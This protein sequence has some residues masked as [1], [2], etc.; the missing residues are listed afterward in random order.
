MIKK[1][2]HYIYINAFW[3]GFV[4]KKDPNNID[5]FKKIFLQSK[6]LKNFEITT[7]IH[8]ANVLFESISMFGQSLTTIKNWKYKIHYSGEPFRNNSLDYDLVLDSEKSKDNNIVDLPLCVYYT[9]E[10]CRL[11]KLLNRQCITKIPIEFCC[12]IVSNGNC[13]IRNN[14]F[15]VLN[16]YKKVHSYGRFANNMG[17]DSNINHGWGTD[18]YINFIRK[19]KFIICFENTKKGTYITEKIVNPYLAQIVPIYWGT[20]HVKNIF[21]VES[22]LFLEDETTESFVKLVNRIIELDNDDKKYLE[23]VNSQTLIIDYWNNHYTIDTIARKIDSV[24]DIW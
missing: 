2:K 15:E 1:I 20:H 8:Q 17:P 6:K 9:H 23:C 21:N 10:N 14:V 19:Y 11:D 7:D 4:D 13:H 24:F 3:N 16:Q 12:F 22:M 5:F 18:E